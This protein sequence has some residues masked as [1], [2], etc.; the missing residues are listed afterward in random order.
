[1]HEKDPVERYNLLAMALHWLVAIL[2]AVVGVLGLVLEA[3]PKS[4]RLGVINL[5][6]AL[7][8]LL[9]GLILLRLLWRWAT[10]GPGP[11]PTWSGWMQRA[12]RLAH[13]GL[14]VLMLAVPLVGIIAYVWHGR[15]FDFGLMRLDLGLGSVK[16]I[17]DPAEELHEFLAFA[18]MGLVG[19]HILGALWHQYI[20]RDQIFR[21]ILPLRS[22]GLEKP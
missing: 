19:L 15:A 18:L 7:G 10:G 21:R 3:F 12:S 16:W 6:A 13:L 9:F 20:A 11:D 22:E 14:Y 4:T 5:H 1:M 8:L 17:Y 2:L